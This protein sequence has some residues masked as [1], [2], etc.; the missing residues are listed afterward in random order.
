VDLV[1]E[2]SQTTYRR[3]VEVKSLGRNSPSVPA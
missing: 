3:F 1:V 2:F